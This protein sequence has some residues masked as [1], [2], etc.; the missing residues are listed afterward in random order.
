MGQLS[1]RARRSSRIR[2]RILDLIDVLRR[3]RARLSPHSKD[4]EAELVE[5]R[6]EI[7]REIATARRVEFKTINDSYLRTIHVEE[8]D[9]LILLWLRDGDSLS[10]CRLLGQLTNAN[11]TERQALRSFFSD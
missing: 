11:E 6:N 4:V 10:I 8:F 2:Q 9:A 3:V 7:G 1:V 5:T